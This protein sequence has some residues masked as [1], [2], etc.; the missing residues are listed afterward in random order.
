MPAF[1]HV[2]SGAFRCDGEPV[3]LTRQANSEIADVDHFL[4]F[5]QAF[6]KNFAALYRNKTP[7][8]VFMSTQ[9]LS[10]ETHKLA[11]TRRD[12]HRDSF[13]L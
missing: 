4:D 9:F 10:E 12:D 5:A 7:K 11:A 3:L 6:G 8:I 2:V 1:P 13:T